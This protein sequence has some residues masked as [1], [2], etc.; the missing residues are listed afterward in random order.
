MNFSYFR[1]LFLIL[2][3]AAPIMGAADPLNEAIETEVN[4][5]KAAARSQKKIDQMSD[6]TRQMLEEYRQV[7]REIET[8]KTYNRHLKQLVSAQQEEKVSLAKQLDEIEV[9]RRE[10]VPLMLRMVESLERFIQLDMPFLPQERQLRLT[11]LKEMMVQPDVTES[12]K[13]RRLLEAYQIENDYGRTIEAYRADLTLN[14]E[15]RPVDFLRVGRV[16]LFYQ[17]LDASETGAWNKKKKQWERLSAEYRKSIRDGLRIA[18]K[19]AAPD[20]LTLALPLP[21]AVR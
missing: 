3:L 5:H 14:G 19:E 9:T 21:E 15:S 4:T 10:I 18:R 6:Q 16:A 12:E 20:L 2:V 1:W 8:L 11:Q 13:F 17:T 7:T